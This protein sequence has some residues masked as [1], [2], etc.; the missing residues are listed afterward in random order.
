[1]LVPKYFQ[2]QLICFSYRLLHYS[3][4]KSRC[5]RFGQI[6]YAEIIL[7][8]WF[9]GIAIELFFFTSKILH[10]VVN[11]TQFRLVWIFGFLP[12]LYHL[13]NTERWLHCM[14]KKMKTKTKIQIYIL[15]DELRKLRLATRYFV[16]KIGEYNTQYPRVQDYYVMHDCWSEHPVFFTIIKNIFGHI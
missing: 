10:F 2:A 13:T 15:D 6:V 7:K 14:Y 1:M 4:P 9:I 16:S 3:L 8:F 5:C 12:T 11:K